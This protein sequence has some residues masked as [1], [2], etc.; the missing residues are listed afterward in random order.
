MGA[1]K[2]MKTMKTM[3]ITQYA[4]QVVPSNA[5]W[6]FTTRRVNHADVSALSHSFYSVMS[7]DLILAEVQQ[8][9]QH[10]KL[11]LAE[12]RTSH[13]ACGDYVVLACADRYAP[14]QFHGYAEIDA[15][16]SDMLAAGGLI[17]KVYQAH[18]KMIPPTQLRPVGIL[19]DSDGE[20]INVA[21]YALS[22]RASLSDMTVIFVVGASMNAGKTTATSSLGHGLV[23]AGYKVAGIKATGTGA[24]GDFNAMLDSGLHSVSDFTD[25]GMASTYMQSIDRIEDGLRVLLADAASKG[26]EIAVVELADGIYQKE[27][28]ELLNSSDYIREV[29]DG[30]MFACGDAVSAVGGVQHLRMLGY[31]PFAVSGLVSLSPLAVSEAEAA[32][33]IVVK[34]REALMSPEEASALIEGLDETSRTSES[35]AA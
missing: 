8:I 35:I 16:G 23:K 11:Q 10:K 32:A 14:D 19:L 26:A 1:I 9:G 3:N 33:N 18:Q 4:N 22:Q 20:V 5:K 34:T 17:G 25:A 12:G 31:E 21:N 27:T 13:L 6:A 30:I 2:G 29:F 28:C 7:G 24:F 15:D